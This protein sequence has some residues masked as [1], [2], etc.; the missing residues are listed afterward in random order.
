MTRKEAE[1]LIQEG[2]YLL[3]QTVTV[4]DINKMTYRYD[5]LEYTVQELKMNCSPD[6]SGN[7]SGAEIC[8]AFAVLKG[9][10]D[11]QIIFEG[12]RGLMLSN[13]PEKYSA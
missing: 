8:N 11:S 9:V 2:Q 1:Q 13:P 7:F 12:L 4:R 5:T 3:G 6:N 10:R